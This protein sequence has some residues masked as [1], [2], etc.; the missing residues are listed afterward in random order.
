MFSYV[1]LPNRFIWL[2]A[3]EEASPLELYNVPLFQVLKAGVS[4]H[5]LFML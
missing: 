2:I 4:Q 1:H 3:Y 5:Q